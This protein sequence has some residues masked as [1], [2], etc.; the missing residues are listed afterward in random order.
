MSEPSGGSLAIKKPEQIS[1][2]AMDSGDSLSISKPDPITPL[3]M[4]SSPPPKKPQ[5]RPPATSGG[6][7][8]GRSEMSFSATGQMNFNMDFMVGEKVANINVNG[9]E[10]LSCMMDDYKV[11]IKEGLG[12]ILEMPG[13]AKLTI[14]VDNSGLS[15]KKKV[16]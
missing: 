11:V 8:L 14:P 13:G 4:D 16:G 9:D 10:G 3:A 7:S 2:L 15:Q 6:A 1:P 5:S 12:F